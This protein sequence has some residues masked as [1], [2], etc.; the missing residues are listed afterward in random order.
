[1]YSYTVRYEEVEAVRE[2]RGKCPTC[3]KWVVRKHSVINTVNPFNKNADGYPKTHREVR[4]AVEAK[5]NEWVPNFEHWTCEE[6]RGPLS[7]EQAFLV[8]QS[9]GKNPKSAA[10]QMALVDAK[11]SS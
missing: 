9:L 6:A 7:Q 8:V 5:A 10:I 2:Q 4:E 3:G 11:A 1:M